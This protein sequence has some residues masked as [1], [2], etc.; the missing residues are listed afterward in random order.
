MQSC[1]N[2]SQIVVLCRD[3][4]YTRL[5]LEQEVSML[6]W[7]LACT[8]TNQDTAQRVD[9]ITAFRSGSLDDDLF[10]QHQPET[11]DCPPNGF[12]V[13]VNHWRFRLTFV[14]MR[15]WSGPRSEMFQQIRPLKRSFYIQVCGL[16][17]VQRHT[18]PSVSMENCSG[19]SPT[20][21]IEYRVLLLRSLI[22]KQVPMGSTVHLHL[23]NHGAND[24]KIGYFQP[25][26]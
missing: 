9:D 24:W 15:L 17:K 6:L 12:R 18:L 7:L 11:I 25:V 14:T 10:S 26:D 21:S 13:E 3:S 20:H 23:H 16:W 4:L 8:Q 19:K 22:L 2:I 1:S 5:Y